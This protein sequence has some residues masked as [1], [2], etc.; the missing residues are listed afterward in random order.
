MT[1][2]TTTEVIADTKPV[3]VVAPVQAVV[4]PPVPDIVPSESP[5]PAEVPPVEEVPKEPEAE[6]ATYSDPEDVAIVEALK[7]FEV[8]ATQAQAVFGKATETGNIGDV[9]VAKLKEL[10]G[11]VKANLLLNSVKTRFDQVQAANKA[12]ETAVYG[13]V[14][15]EANMKTI[16]EWARK[17]EATSSE[18]KA[19]LDTYRGMLN[20]NPTQAGLAAQ[21]LLTAYNADPANKTLSITMQQGT[22]SN[23]TNYDSITRADYFV[24][25]EA[26]HRKGDKV[27]M[28][29]L[30][31][32]RTASKA[33][34]TFA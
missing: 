18:F 3:E 15:G 4:V 5:K 27:A 11:D 25:F 10:V 1:E 14:G 21:A 7:T 12:Q 23:L 33:R 26:A 17:A 34:G 24:A 31:N 30:D 16:A 29:V 19:K 20:A 28:A 2:P 13:V 32:R 22:V 6:Y 9:D 8:T